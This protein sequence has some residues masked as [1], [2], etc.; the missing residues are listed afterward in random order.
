VPL[1][2]GSGDRIWTVAEVAAVLDYSEAYITR[3][4]EAGMLPRNAAVVQVRR[5]VAVLQ[6]QLE[7]WF[8]DLKVLMK[9][10]DVDEGA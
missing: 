6:A 10:V 1:F 3:R 8:L 4:A 9:S 7:R 5:R 2:D